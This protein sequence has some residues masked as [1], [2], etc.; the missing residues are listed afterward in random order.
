MTFDR[1]WVLLLLP[2]P[3]AWIAW[4]WRR[5]YRRLS[6]VLKT[7][8]IVAVILALAGPVMETSD[9]KVAVAALVDTS[10][11]ITSGDLDREGVARARHAVREG[12]EPAGRNSVCAS[13]SESL[14]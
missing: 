11:S 12:I 6:L 8:M 10:A 7:A 2:L 5:Q 9:K 4:E 3:L 1:V 14:G 13:A